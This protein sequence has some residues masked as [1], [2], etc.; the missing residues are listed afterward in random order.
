MYDGTAVPT[1]RVFRLSIRCVSSLPFLIS[2]WCKYLILFQLSGDLARSA[3]FH[4]HI[5]DTLNYR[6]GFRINNPVLRIIRI[7]HIPVRYIGCQRKSF[8]SLCLLNSSDLAAGIS[9]IEFIK[10]VFDTGKVIVD[11]VR[12]IGIKV[13]I[14]GDIPDPIFWEGHTGIKP[15][16]G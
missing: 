7:L 10:P 8:F 11:A 16:K 15:D 12:V 9:G 4:T 1:I 13:I 3:S 14:D 5:K 2:S 6:C